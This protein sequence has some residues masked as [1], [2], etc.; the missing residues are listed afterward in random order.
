[1]KIPAPT[2][3]IEER[4][5]MAARCHDCDE[6]P[7]VPDAGLVFA[8]GDGRRL[9]LMHNGLHILADG[10][11]GAWMTE[12]IRLCNGH[13]EPQEERMFHEVVRRLP[14]NA[15]MIE[16]GGYWA[17]YTLWFLKD[18]AQRSATVLEPE[19]V[20]LEVGRINAGLNGLGPEF[21]HGFAGATFAGA[22]PFLS[23]TSGTLKLP[24]YSVEKLMARRGLE[25]LDLL[26]CDIQGAEVNT[27]DGC[28]ALFRQRRIGW[29]FVS[30]H[31]HAI[32]GDPLTHQRCLDIL[33]DCGAII[34]AE[35]DV[36]ESFSGDGLIVARFAAPPA[37]WMPVTLSR[38]RQS[39]SLFR[40]LAYDLDACQQ[41]VAQLQAQVTASM[42]PSQGS[43]IRRWVGLGPRKP[44]S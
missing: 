14:D 32:S 19:P 37:D 41:Q 35:H 31:A 2:V 42:Q 13:H 38:N 11:C 27:L 3:S 4:V 43:S 34:E 15:T 40:H 24:R 33:R 9:Q 17:Y 12:L 8:D 39:T 7:K 23:G 36:H 30:T 18:H 29:V 25:Y 26:H 22:A 44:P 5:A 10:Y 28:R 16:L 6:I 21:L 1:M 20:H